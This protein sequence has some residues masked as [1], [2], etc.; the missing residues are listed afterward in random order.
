MAF[1]TVQKLRD[2]M[3]DPHVI[4]VYKTLGS[5]GATFRWY[6]L[7]RQ[8]V[9]P[10]A[11]TGLPPSTTG[12]A[13]DRTS[14]GA[15]PIPTLTAGKKW[16]L[17]RAELL[18]AAS[19]NG[20]LML[21][22]RLVQTGGLSGTVTTAQTVNSVALPSRGGGGD[23]VECWLEVHTAVG[24]T[25][26]TATVTYTNEAGTSGRTGTT[27]IGAGSQAAGMSF[28][29]IKLQAGDKGVRSVQSVQ[30]SAT[31]GTAGNFG[32]TLRKRICDLTV[33][34][35]RW[36]AKDLDWLGL[37]LPPIDQDA[38]IEI[39]SNNLSNAQHSACGKLYLAEVDV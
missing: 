19:M 39:M 6:S 9:F 2:A 30:L 12:A 34:P 13:L 32:V 14:S 18:G 10:P 17:A 7:Y 26:V 21:Y 4:E 23:Q 27:A 20:V 38:C 36:E 3:A 35:S 29:P 33:F 24:T 8:G 11:P 15:M 22:D 28:M 37:G 5:P 31:T 1:D 16:V 25:S